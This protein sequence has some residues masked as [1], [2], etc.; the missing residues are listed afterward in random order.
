VRDP[1]VH[2][3]V[4]AGFLESA[5]RCGYAVRGLSHSP[6]KGPEG[7]IEYLAFL[8]RGAAADDAVD[9]AA[10]VAAAHAELVG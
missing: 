2:R 5:A 6:V 10:A 3:A 7:N 4:L 9:P 1:A 8:A